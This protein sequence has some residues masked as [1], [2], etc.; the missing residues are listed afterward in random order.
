[1]NRVGGDP[2]RRRK[3]VGKRLMEGGGRQGRG[4]QEGEEKEVGHL[5]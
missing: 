2:E 4:D 1:M 3:G 5:G